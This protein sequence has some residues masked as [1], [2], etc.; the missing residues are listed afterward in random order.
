MLLLF[1]GGVMNLAW[2]A[3]LGIVVL[4]EKLAPPHWHAERY[5]AAAFATGAVTVL[6][7]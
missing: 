1:A 7:L 6:L 2:V 5:V 3:I 4:G